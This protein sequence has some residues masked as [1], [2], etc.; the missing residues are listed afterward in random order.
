MLVLLKK[1]K[2]PEEGGGGK[3]I[4]S[5]IGKIFGFLAIDKLWDGV[6]KIFSFDIV[7]DVASKAITGSVSG[8]TP[9]DEHIGFSSLGNIFGI[10]QYL[11][12]V[13]GTYLDSYLKH[14]FKLVYREIVEFPEA[15]LNADQL[16]QVRRDKYNALQFIVAVGRSAKETLSGGGPAPQPPQPARGAQ[17]AQQTPQQPAPQPQPQI[18]VLQ[19]YGKYKTAERML[20][21]AFDGITAGLNDQQI[22]DIIGQNILA[23][24]IDARVKTKMDDATYFLKDNLQGKGRQAGISVAIFGVVFISVLIFLAFF[25]WSF[26]Q[27]QMAL[28]QGLI[29]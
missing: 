29:K 3:M 19:H 7:K 13:G 9:D 21:G 17:P 4:S 10:C 26:F 6:K 1:H 11:G 18:L 28:L 27:G 8:K 25:A 16:R 22:M 12:L 2:M 14:L 20:F 24:G 15:G 23:G 5:W